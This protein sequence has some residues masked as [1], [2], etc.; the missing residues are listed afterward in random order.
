MSAA[1]S[2]RSGA[3]RVSLTVRLAFGYFRF[4][5]SNCH[6]ASHRRASRARVCQSVVESAPEFMHSAD[7]RTPRGAPNR[8]GAVRSYRFSPR[9]R[10]WHVSRSQQSYDTLIKSFQPRHR[11]LRRRASFPSLIALFNL[12]VPVFGKIL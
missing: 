4:F 8:Q 12:L 10:R 7:D 9:R 2:S 11:R 5:R 6:W 1:S 3:S